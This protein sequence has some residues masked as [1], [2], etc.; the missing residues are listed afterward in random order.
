MQHSNRS[1]FSLN[2]SRLLLPGGNASGFEQQHTRPSNKWLTTV[3]NLDF[4]DYLAICATKARYCRCLDA[5]DWQG[6]ADVFTEDA[7]L[8]ATGSGGPLTQGRDALVHSVRASID[9]AITVHQ[10]HSPEITMLDRNRTEVVW[11]M[12][13]RVI[14]DDARARQI[15]KH[16]LTGYGHYRDSMIRCEDGIWRITRSVLSRLHIELTD[17]TG[18]E[19]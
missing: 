10:V 4:A 3:I 7:V 5:K 8:D 9:T 19:T 1:Q 2:I 16:S 18:S 6:Y 15:G 13:D 17:Y 11:A 14:W 12:Q